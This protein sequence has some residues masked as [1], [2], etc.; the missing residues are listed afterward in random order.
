MYT[1]FQTLWGVVIW[2]ILNKIYRVPTSLG[3][4]L[5]GCGTSWRR[6]QCAKEKSF[7][8]QCPR[9]HATDKMAPQTKQTEYTPYSRPKWQ[10]LYL[11]SDY[12]CLK[13]IPIGAAHI[14]ITYRWELEMPTPIWYR[15]SRSFASHLRFFLPNTFSHR[16]F[17]PIH[18][19]FSPRLV[20]CS[21]PV[22]RHSV[23]VLRGIPAS[24]TQDETAGRQTGLAGT[25]Q[26]SPGFCFVR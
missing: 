10:N 15:V 5:T 16:A 3:T 4:R 17:L 19:D 13:M 21:A 9:Q 12:K 2:A 14:H 6:K 18:V 22:L 26:R 7:A 8:M 20:D 24:R 23:A 25:S 1:P 11:I